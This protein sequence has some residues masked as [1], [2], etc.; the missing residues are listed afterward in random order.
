MKTAFSSQG[1]LIGAG[2]GFGTGLI[3]GGVQA[4]NQISNV[5]INS[6]TKTWNEPRMQDQYVGQIPRNHYEPNSPFGISISNQ[7]MRDVSASNPVLSNGKPVMDSKTQT[8]SDHGTP[9]VTERTYNIEQKSLNKQNPCYVVRNEDSHTVYETKRVWQ[10]DEPARKA[11]AKYD[12]ATG[13]YTPARDIPEKGHYETKEVPVGKVVHGYDVSY[14]PNYV[15]RVIGT[16]NKPD[17]KFETG[18]NTF[19][20]MMGYGLGFAALGAVAG[21]FIKAQMEN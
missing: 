2:I 18:V 17:V 6:V 20:L 15:S 1:A 13:K 4:H 16:Y 11:E 5:P 10:V 12:E 21:G 19:G 3:V 8:W 7:S 14:S 9:V